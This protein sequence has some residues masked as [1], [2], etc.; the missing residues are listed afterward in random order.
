VPLLGDTGRVERHPRTTHRRK[1]KKTSELLRDGYDTLLV[2]GIARGIYVDRSG[3]VCSLGALG[4]RFGCDFTNGQREAGRALAR[5]VG[6]SNDWASSL[7]HWNDKSS[8]DVVLDGWL[9][10]IKLAEADES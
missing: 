5:A 3:K 9:K 8:D 2:K 4:V 7:V 1:A 6:G 10:A